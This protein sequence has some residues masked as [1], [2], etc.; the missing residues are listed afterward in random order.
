MKES[1][2][3][4][5][6]AARMLMAFLLV[7]P[8]SSAFGSELGLFYH[9]HQATALLEQVSRGDCGEDLGLIRK[10]LIAADAELGQVIMRSGSPVSPLEPATQELWELFNNRHELKVDQM[11]A[12][13]LRL[14]EKAGKMRLRHK[15]AW[16]EETAFCGAGDPLMATGR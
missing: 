4:V 3:L 5:R 15:K 13:R 16:H 10:H 12:Y 9:L 2:A 8:G 1:R 7:A 6:L 14:H 11:E